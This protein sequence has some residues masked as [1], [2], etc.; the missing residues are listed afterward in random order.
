MGYTN[1]N[2]STLRAIFTTLGWFNSTGG[3]AG[4]RWVISLAFVAV[5]V[6][7]IVRDRLGMIL[8]TLVVL[9]FGAFVFDP[10]SVIWNERIVPFWFITI[11]L[12]VGL[13]LR[14]H[15]CRVGS[16]TPSGAATGCSRTSKE[17]KTAFQRDDVDRRLEENF[18]GGRSTTWNPCRVAADRRRRPFPCWRSCDAEDTESRVARRTMRATVAVIV[19]GLATT[20]PGLM[21]HVATVIGSEHDR[22]S[23]LQLGA[24]GTTRATRPSPRG[25]STTT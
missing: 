17:R 2:V 20:V 19:L 23:G 4:D 21:P 12:S 18:D 6:A 14:L 3:V 5:V 7:F 24:A 9:S 1:V 25:P 11:H 10:Q 16:N 22:E 13:A 15:R 8:A